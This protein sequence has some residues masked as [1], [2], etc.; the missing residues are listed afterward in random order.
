MTLH[1]DLDAQLR[2]VR[3]DQGQADKE[4]EDLRQKRLHALA[5]MEEAAARIK[6]QLPM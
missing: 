2:K 3:F 6:T 4:F 1:A 5:E